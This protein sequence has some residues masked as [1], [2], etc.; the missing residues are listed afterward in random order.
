MLPLSLASSGTDLA[1][2]SIRGD[3]R[4]RT[5]LE[6]LGFVPGSNI[7]VV[8]SV[9]GN[10]IIEVRDTRIALGREL[11]VKVMVLEGEV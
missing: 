4:Q 7:R 8:S 10:L 9:S 2:V 3:D 5:F 6:S 11:A 1:V